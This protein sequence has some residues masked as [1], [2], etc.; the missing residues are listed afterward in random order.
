MQIL[1]MSGEMT[2]SELD[3]LLRFPSSP[4]PSPVDF[5]S[6]VGWGAIK[7]LSSIDE[8]RSVRQ[9]WQGQ[10]AERSF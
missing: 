9:G 6:D 8:F 3:L 1:L 7:M 2:G 4:C 10:K 5:L